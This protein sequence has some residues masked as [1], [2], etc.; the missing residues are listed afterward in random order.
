MLPH[1]WPAF[2]ST[3]LRILSNGKTYMYDELL[4]AI[5]VEHELTRDQLN[6]TLVNGYNVFATRVDHALGRLVTKKAIL[7]LGPL[8]GPVGYQIT[9]YGLGILRQR[10]KEVRIKDL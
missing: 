4:S 9:E 7:K 5:A 6:L 3:I 10:G 2:I 1:G 8:R